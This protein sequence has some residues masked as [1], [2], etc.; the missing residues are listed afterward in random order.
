M[1]ALP[2]QSSEQ[3]PSAADVEH[4]TGLQI[5]KGR[6]RERNMVPQDQSAVH[7]LEAAAAEL[8]GANQ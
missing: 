8:S 4:R 3:R 2:Q 5:A 7:L 6:I 1:A